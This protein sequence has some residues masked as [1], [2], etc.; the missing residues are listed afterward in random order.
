[1]T[2]AVLREVRLYGELGRRFGRV[3]R[4]AIST[5]HEAVRA[6]SATVRGFADYLFEHNLPGFRVF[7]DRA[8]RT[9]EQL[10][11]PFG[12]MEVVKIVPVIAGRKSGA[13]QLILAGVLLFFGAPMLG[14]LI[15]STSLGG[16]VASVGMSIG[17]ALILGGVLQLLS[18]QRRGADLA[19][20]VEN[21]PSYAFDGPVN[22]TQQGLPVPLVYGRIITGGAPISSGLLAEEP[23]PAAGEAATEQELPPEQPAY[24]WQYDEAAAG[25]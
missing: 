22:Q 11:E 1:M 4:L 14:G 8:G 10:H 23:V 24:W 3:H 25:P 2:A 6:L 17:K 9:L 5:P 18:P 16:A 19:T 7:V 20:N 12:R 15:S 21:A 13:F